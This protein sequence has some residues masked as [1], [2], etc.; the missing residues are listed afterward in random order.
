MTSWRP[1]LYGL[2]SVR[3]EQVR[4]QARLPNDRTERPRA[5]LPV[6]RYWDGGRAGGFVPLH[7]NVTPAL[8]DSLEAVILQNAAGFLP[9][10]HSEPS[11]QQPP[12]E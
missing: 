11:Q 5:E 4:S 12:S 7:D 6:K 9:R 2:Q 10:E 1:T 3:T 8:P